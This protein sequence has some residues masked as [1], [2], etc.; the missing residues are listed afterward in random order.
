MNL[1]KLD[2]ATKLKAISG[3]RSKQAADYRTAITKF[4][5][6]VSMSPNNG[7]KPVWA[8]HPLGSVF[9]N[10]QSYLYAFHENVLKRALR[11]AGTALDRNGNQYSKIHFFEQILK[12][13]W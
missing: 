13:A 3:P 8:N 4:S 7:L 5:E 6:Q 1:D 12:K 10:L 2:D 11:L 9:F